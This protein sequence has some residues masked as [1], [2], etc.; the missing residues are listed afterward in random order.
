MDRVILHCDFN[1]FFASVACLDDESLEGKPVA[2]CGSTEQRHGI[3]LAKNELAKACGVKTGEPIWQAKTKCPGLVTVP[4][5]FNRYVYFSKLAREIFLK[6]TDRVE[7]FSIDESWLDVT[8]ST[9]M[10]GGGKKIADTL[11]QTIKKELGLTVSVGVSFNKVF[12]KIGS[13]YKK[14][15]ATTVITRENY[16]DIIWGLPACAMLGVG[17]NTE[18]RLNSLGIFTIGDIAGASPDV[19]SSKLY[20]P[21]LTLWNY[22]NARD[23]SPVLSSET[24][25]PP[26]SIGR[27]TTCSHDIEDFAELHELLLLLSEDVASRLRK[28]GF[29]ANGVQVSLRTFDLETSSFQCTLPHSTAITQ[30]IEAAGI[31]LIKQNGGIKK[32]LRSIGIRVFSLTAGNDY[33]IS[34]LDNIQKQQKLEKIEASI[35]NIRNR[36]GAGSICRAVFLKKQGAAAEFL[37]TEHHSFKHQP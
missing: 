21:G 18:R 7:A 35:D 37:N 11:R 6:F 13:D 5:N 16:K 30:V 27:S 23:I 9:R 10:F 4:P 24:V 34:I 19:L 8:G 33:Q 28:W 20:K 22:A 12:A 1:N 25:V 26:K 31:N 15:D 17:P 14:P 29:T 36:F 2:V 32:P 3:V